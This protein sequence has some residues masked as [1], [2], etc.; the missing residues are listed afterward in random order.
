MRLPMMQ[1]D[2]WRCYGWIGHT[3]GLKV[4]ELMCVCVCVCVYIIAG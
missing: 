3:D 4:V 1:L 2:V